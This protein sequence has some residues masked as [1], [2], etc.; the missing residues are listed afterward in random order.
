[1]KESVERGDI[2]QDYFSPFLWET[3]IDRVYDAADEMPSLGGLILELFRNADSVVTHIYPDLQIVLNGTT[4]NEVS[5][6][7]EKGLYM[8]RDDMMRA[9]HR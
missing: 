9:F 1:M 6:I 4:F 5:S 3:I 7:D 8:I 2:D